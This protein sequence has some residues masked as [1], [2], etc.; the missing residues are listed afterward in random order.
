MAKVLYTSTFFLN[1]DG[2][3]RKFLIPAEGVKTYQKRD[4]CLIKMKAM[5]GIYAKPTPEFLKLRNQMLNARR[6][7][8]KMGWMSEVPIEF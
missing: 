5:G 6:K 7:I 2:S 3:G 4:A 8:E 1:E